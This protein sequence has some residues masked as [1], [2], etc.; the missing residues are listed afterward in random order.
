MQMYKLLKEGCSLEATLKSPRGVGCIRNPSSPE[1]A[2]REFAF[3]LAWRH[4]IL[5]P[6]RSSK[7][8]C[9][10]RWAALSLLAMR[11]CHC[12]SRPSCHCLCAK[13]TKMETPFSNVYQ[14]VLGWSAGHARYSL[15]A[16]ALL[17]MTP[18][19][20]PGP[21]FMA[22]A[23]SA[24]EGEERTGAMTT[25][26]GRKRVQC[27]MTGAKAGQLDVR[28]SN[29]SSIGHRYTFGV[30]IPLTRSPNALPGF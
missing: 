14:V 18:A 27:S 8:E 28:A 21:S 15:H 22:S 10:I 16:P 19:R 29:R 1:G 20:M 23:F 30:T 17:A 24:R 4:Y 7:N 2:M 12:T 5:E 3:L 11:S 25:V 6:V 13:R 26:C 9:R